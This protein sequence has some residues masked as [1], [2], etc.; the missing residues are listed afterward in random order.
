MSLTISEP[1]TETA[2]TVAD[3]SSAINSSTASTATAS[4]ATDIREDL[5]RRAFSRENLRWGN[6]SWP[7]LGWFAFMHI[8]CLAAP[9]FFSWTGVVLCVVMHWLTAS[10]GICLGY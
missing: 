8:G 7:V 10:I 4:T 6:L 1:K 2:T 5:L 9:F 3:P